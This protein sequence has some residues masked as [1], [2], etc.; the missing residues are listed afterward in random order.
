MDTPANSKPIPGNPLAASIK[1]IKG[2]GPK[3]AELFSKKGVDT[4]EDALYFVPRAYED[5]RKITKINQLV[6]GSWATVLAKV[7]TSRQIGRGRFARLEVFVS[8]G[9]GQLGLSWFHAPPYLLAEFATGN[10]FLIYGEVKL[11]S[12]IPRVSHPEYELQKDLEDGKP[13]PSANFGRIIPVYSETQGLHQKTIRRIMAEVL[14][15]TLSHLVDPL[16]EA[17]RQRLSLPDLR[18]SFI[19]VHYPKEIPIEKTEEMEVE[20][21]SPAL[22]RI[23]F[24]EFF[25]LQ[26]GLGMRK[27]H[28]R[29][30]IAPALVDE[31]NAVETFLK[32]LPFELTKDQ[33]AAV[34]E[35]AAD[36]AQPRAMSRLMQGDVGAGKTVV[37]MAAGCIAASHGYQTALM[38]PTEL[39]AQQHF[40]T[41]KKW[42]VPLG[43]HSELLVGGNST[44]KEVQ[45]SIATGTAKFVIGTHALFQRGVSFDK[46]GL[47]VIDEQHRFGVEQRTALLKKSQKAVPHLLMMTATPIP[48]TLSLTLYGDLDLTILRQKPAGRKPIRTIILRDRERPRLYNKMRQTVQQGQQVYVIYP[49]VEESEKLELKSATT[50]HAKLSKEIFP[51]IPTALLHG[52]MKAE[53]KDQILRDFNAGKYRILVST[54]VIEVGIDVPNATLMVIEHPERLGLSQLHQL[55]GRVGRGHLESFCVLMVESFVNP[56]LRVMEATEDGFEIAEED[57]KIRGPGEFLGTRQSGL[58]GFRVGHILKDASLLGVA[59]DEAQ[60]ILQRD[61]DLRAPEHAGIRTMV[62]SRWKEKIERLRSG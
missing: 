12:G 37:A 4:L 38:V 24:E 13:R 7:V 39:L 8:D 56:R 49:L 17:L 33:R 14:R 43:I 59:R 16:P 45:E 62:E 29:S 30:E 1:Y 35:I 51:E 2:V 46:L 15:A 44:K 34:A 28:R 41:A 53:E 54:T 61:P 40:N 50:M 55:R 32:S 58:P 25:I 36:M 5:R 10:L 60:R 47:V 23:I 18:E 52:R 11:F 9:T 48:R 22:R 31:S 3:L 57:L 26:L 42:L 21:Y 19:S 20:E 27:K 6:E